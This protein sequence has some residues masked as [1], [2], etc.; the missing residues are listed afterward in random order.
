MNNVYYFI[1]MKFKLSYKNNLTKIANIS[2]LM[3]KIQ[4]GGL[5]VKFAFLLQFMFRQS[6]CADLIEIVSDVPTQSHNKLLHL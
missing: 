1:S 2:L 5:K 6:C 3:C 4:R